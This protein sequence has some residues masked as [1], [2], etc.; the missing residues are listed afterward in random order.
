MAPLKSQKLSAAKQKPAASKK[1]E[2]L[3]PK[4]TARATVSSTKTTPAPSRHVS[5]KEEE[6][7]EPTSIG[8]TLSPDADHVMEEVDSEDEKSVIEVSDGEY[9]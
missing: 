5:V 6:D 9:N 2:V 8:R 3:N 1:K 7:D 4:P